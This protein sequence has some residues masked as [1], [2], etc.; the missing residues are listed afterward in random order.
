MCACSPPSGKLH[1]SLPAALSL[2]V[3][4]AVLKSVG[5]IT[6]LPLCF[7]FV[8]VWGFAP[9][10]LP[11][12]YCGGS[13]TIFQCAIVFYLLA[14]WLNPALGLSCLTCLCQLLCRSPHLLSSVA[15]WCSSDSS[16]ASVRILSHGR[17]RT[18][19]GWSPECPPLGALAMCCL[20]PLLEIIVQGPSLF[21]TVH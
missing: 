9:L 3:L 15:P 7:P 16:S 14:Y 5:H 10:L 18:M 21:S 11:F 13:L 6:H 8:S 2:F 12:C 17:T 1:C 4:S 19:V 20:A